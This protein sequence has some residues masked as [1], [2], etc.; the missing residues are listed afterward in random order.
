MK[1]EI[2]QI[3]N[4][5]LRQTARTLTVEEILSPE[6]QQLIELM[7]TTMYSAPG[8]GLAAPQIGSAL[9]LIVIEDKEEYQR[10]FSAEELQK[11]KRTPVAFHVIIN[12]KLTL[13][14]MQN[15]EF[16]EG[17]LS[18]NGLCGIVPRAYS[19]K[20]TGLNDRA[21]PIS[22]EAEGWYARILQHEIDHLNGVLCIDHMKTQ[23]L[24]TYENYQKFWRG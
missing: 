6:I 23:S 7:K 12:P 2:I 10:I 14:N 15:I 5:I 19:V 20:V 17:C 24:S 18:V 13:L 21:E 22:I 4:P 3:G 9:Q 1:L 11:R 16:H 8:V